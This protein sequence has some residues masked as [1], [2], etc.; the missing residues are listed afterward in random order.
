MTKRQ[1]LKAIAASLGYVP[2]SDRELLETAAKGLQWRTQRIEQLETMVIRLG[3]WPWSKD[4]N[5]K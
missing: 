2:R 3:G 5:P 1:A 4:G